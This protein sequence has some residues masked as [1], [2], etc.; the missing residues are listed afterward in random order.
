M[1]TRPLGC[2]AI[3]CLGAALHAQ[4]NAPPR[5]QL[6]GGYT[7]L[8]NSLNGVSG[9]HQPLNGGEIGFAIPP[10]HNL[11]FKMSGFA[12]DGANL[13]ASEHPYFIVAGGQYGK[14]FGK[15]SAFVE[16]LGG[17]GEVN[18]NWGAKQAIGDTASFAA[19]V[20]GGVDT[21][22]SP[23]FA[24]RVQGDLQ[25]SYFKEAA[26][27]SPTEGVLSYVPGLP[28]FFGRISSGIVWRF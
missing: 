10:W 21:P 18:A 2:M 13:G 12:Y 22:I 4:T 3:L 28:V 6:F 11:R 24:F 7:F 8:S 16:A 14:N 26:R 5:Y 17:E 27:T 15:E 25:Y 20:G 19:I 23:R 1:L 9:S